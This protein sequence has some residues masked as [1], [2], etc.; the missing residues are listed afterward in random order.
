MS[1]ATATDATIKNEEDPYIWL[2]E[3]ESEESL[4]FAKSSN[5]ECL[6]ALGDPTKGPT[7]D[8]ILAVLESKDR[9]PYASKMGLNE[10]GEEVLFN[11]WK[12]AA[13]PKGT[14]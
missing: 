1:A 5:D 11:F 8:R 7:Y 13:N 2:E 4:T 14:Y 3:V 12:D 10:Q 9:I 6:K